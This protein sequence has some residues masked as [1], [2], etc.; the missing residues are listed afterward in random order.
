MYRKHQ[1]GCSCCST[2]LWSC[3]DLTGCLYNTG[4][5]SIIYVTLRNFDGE[6]P[7]Q[8][9]TKLKYSVGCTSGYQSGGFEGPTYPPSYCLFSYEGNVECIDAY[10]LPRLGLSI[11]NDLI[12]V[13]VVFGPDVPFSGYPI[14]VY[15]YLLS[16]SEPVSSKLSTMC[17]GGEANNIS[18][19]FY[20]GYTIPSGGDYYCNS[21]TVSVHMEYVPCEYHY[22]WIRPIDFCTECSYAQ[23]GDK[24]YVRLNLGLNNIFFETNCEDFHPCAGYYNIVY[25]YHPSDIDG[26][27]TFKSNEYGLGT[28]VWDSEF[29]FPTTSPYYCNDM[30]NSILYYDALEIENNHLCEEISRT[31]IQGY[32]TNMSVDIKCDCRNG[33]FSIQPCHSGIAPI[34]IETVIRLRYKLAT[35]DS[36]SDWIC[37]G[38]GDLFL[39]TTCCR[40]GPIFSGYIC[41]ETLEAQQASMARQDFQLP[42]KSFNE[43]YC[44]FDFSCP[45][46][47][48][49]SIYMS[50][51]PFEYWPE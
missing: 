30:K 44:L 12:V 26:E 51:L 21:G 38:L 17:L 19:P 20:T 27:Y 45:E 29:S 41:Y 11:R 47:H 37:V 40:S 28:Y 4:N 33:A 48:S 22:P 16:G 6:F 3:V 24:L 7:C 14:N 8:P 49:S 5:T 23:S 2:N 31:E 34:S 50:R 25:N 18:I 36:W 42:R 1:P 43:D 35:E 39:H 10:K 13:D 46:G 9:R 15:K 32:I